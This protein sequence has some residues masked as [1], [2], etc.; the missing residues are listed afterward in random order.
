MVKETSS[1]WQCE[2]LPLNTLSDSTRHQVVPLSPH[3]LFLI[4]SACSISLV[5]AHDGAVQ[6]VFA[7]QPMLP[8]SVQCEF[9]GSR[10]GGS[11]SGIGLSSFTLGYAREGSRDCVVNS[12]SPA[13]GNEAIAA[14]ALSGGAGGG[15]S[16]WEE[17]VESELRITDPGSWDLVKGKSVIGLRRKIAPRS[18]RQGDL[19]RRSAVSG[20][21]SI[22]SVTWQ[23][24]T[25][26]TDGHA[27]GEEVRNLGQDES[28]TEGFLVVPE[29][30]P[31]VKIG[32]RSVAFCL[33]NTI[34]IASAGSENFS[35][36]ENQNGK[37]IPSKDGRRGRHLGSLRVPKA[38]D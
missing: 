14:A 3:P 10:H 28:G 24:W 4:G 12:Y 20:G 15:W 29:L 13:E 17:A 9:A 33:G 22:S 35:A 16:T 19:R 36:D 38:A 8:R 30:G 23:V 5:S 31:S 25:T 7:T 26:G 6:H 21:S 1:G 37:P 32:T 18:A 34:Q 27:E 2:S 11:Q